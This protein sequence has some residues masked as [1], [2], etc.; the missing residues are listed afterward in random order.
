MTQVSQVISSHR[1]QIDD[2]IQNPNCT[3]KKDKCDLNKSF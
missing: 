2:T 3:K 1:I